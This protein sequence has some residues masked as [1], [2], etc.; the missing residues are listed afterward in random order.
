MGDT[1][2]TKLAEVWQVVE[3]GQTRFVLRMPVDDDRMPQ[4][5]LGMA[6]YGDIVLNCIA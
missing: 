6:I 5:V 3:D 1:H 4:G 2:E